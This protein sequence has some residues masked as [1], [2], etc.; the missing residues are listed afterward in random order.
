MLNH[1]ITLLHPQLANQI[2]AGEVIERPASVIK[3]LMENSLD[4]GATQ[5]DVQVEGGGVQRLC[6]RDNGVGIHK[7]DLALALSRH[8]TSKISSLAELEQVKSLGF[9]GEALASIASV[10][11]L[12]L[13][14][15]YQDAPE[16]WQLQVEGR[17][18]DVRLQP[19]AHPPGA[20]V[21]VRDLFFNTPARRKFLRS[22]KTEFSHI[23]Q[24]IEQ[25]ALGH[26]AVG[27][28]LKQAQR[29]VLQLAPALTLEQRE[30]RV[31]KICGDAF[32]QHALAL[33]IEGQGFVLTGWVALPTFMR[34]QPDL[35][36]FYLNGR[37]IRDK[38]VSHAI[39]QAYHD[40][41]YGDRHPAYVLYLQIDPSTVD[42]NVHPTKQEVRFRESQQVHGFLCKS[43]QQVLAESS[44]VSPPTSFSEDVAQTYK[45]FV[46]AIRES[47]VK[48]T[49]G[50]RAA[51]TKS[52]DGLIFAGNHKDC[53]YSAP[54][55]EKEGGD[56][57][58]PR[59]TPL[60]LMVREQV[61]TYTAL[62]SPAI[63]VVAPP[64]PTTAAPPLGYALGQLH[65]IYILAENQ[66]GLVIVD[67]HAAHERVLYERMKQAHAAGTIAT[68]TSWLP[69]SVNVS[70]KEADYLDGQL[71]LFAELGL[72]IERIAPTS[73]M[74]REAPMLFAQVDVVQ[75]VRDV[76]TDL[77]AE[78]PSARI[79]QQLN[80]V[81][82]TLA[83]RSAAQAKRRLTIPEMNALLRDMEK[84]AHS[85]QCN[86][87]C[88]TCREFSLRELDKLFLRG[89]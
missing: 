43:V 80:H 2:A 27:I 52:G 32:M 21:D 16:A 20:T 8:A 47:P 88:P 55:R 44:V 73:F 40:V 15:R 87:G 38:V 29:V 34:S 23:Q 17:D 5:I 11:R 19:V 89:R 60:P 54:R 25:M 74:L 70:E 82:A 61:A 7:E 37:L 79:E 28:T 69:L 63:D 30:Q 83:C 59:Q 33:E 22:D 84:T 78:Q 14:S 56:F 72:R 68:Q 35:Q 13:S 76:V 31:A 64:A 85:G 36:Y 58:P 9:R 62:A 50:S 51:P 45:N 46:G 65:G 41:Q 67:M 77:M 10:S 57:P 81:L 42:V 4:A 18:A 75:L 53:S 39:K 3:E 86:H 6:V 66:Q 24:R 49:G 12:T 26:F 48:N 1:R 71:A